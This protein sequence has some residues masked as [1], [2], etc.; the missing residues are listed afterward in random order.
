MPHVF[1]TIRPYLVLFGRVLIC[2]CLDSARMTVR[3]R[4]QGR[5]D[6]GNLKN[7]DL[8]V[9]VSLREMTPSEASLRAWVCGAEK[10]PQPSL[11]T[12][13]YR[14]RVGDGHGCHM[15]RVAAIQLLD[16]TPQAKKLPDMPCSSGR[17]PTTRTFQGF[18]LAC[19]VLFRL[20]SPH[21]THAEFHRHRRS[22]FMQASLHPHEP[23][24]ECV[25]S[26]CSGHA[27]EIVG[28]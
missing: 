18:D 23:P 8:A 5:I 3:N 27:A 21:R 24:L 11:P 19:P 15:C 16:R 4:G 12:R 13:F 26:R 7:R 10:R 17:R 1:Y 28:K 9:P 2:A 14:E 6:R 22:P 25:P 20:W